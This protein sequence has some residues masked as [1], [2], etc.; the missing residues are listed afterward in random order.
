MS[1]MNRNY[2]YKHTSAQRLHGLKQ[3]SCSWHTWTYSSSWQILKFFTFWQLEHSCSSLDMSATADTAAL[4]QGE[5]HVLLESMAAAGWDVAPF[6]G[7][8]TQAIFVA[9]QDAS[10]M[11]AFAGAIPD[12]VAASGQLGAA[13]RAVLEGAARYT[14]VHAAHDASALAVLAAAYV[15]ARRPLLIESEDMSLIAKLVTAQE[16]RRS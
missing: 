7:G 9:S 1:F 16:V 13:R 10:G 2:L 11:A 15:A 3:P 5:M 6:L 4:L 12:E 14:F 8:H